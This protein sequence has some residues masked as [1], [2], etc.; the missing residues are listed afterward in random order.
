MPRPVRSLRKKIVIAQSTAVPETSR[1]EAGCVDAGVLERDAAQD[2]IAGKGDH[3]E[4]RQNGN[5]D[6]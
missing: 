3:G 6:K 1:G 5:S 4:H 2:R